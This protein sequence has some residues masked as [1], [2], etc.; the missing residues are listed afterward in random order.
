MPPF[1]FLPDKHGKSDVL[2][3]GLMEWSCN[4]LSQNPN[5]L[6]LVTDFRGK[7]RFIL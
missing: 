1:G 2:C 3:N 5:W 7:R 6:H 4:V